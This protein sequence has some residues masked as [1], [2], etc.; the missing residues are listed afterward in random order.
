MVDRCNLQCGAAGCNSA[1]PPDAAACRHYTDVVL[2]CVLA[3]CTLQ[4]DAI[5]GVYLGIS[6]FMFRQAA[7]VPLPASGGP[8]PKPGSSHGLICRR[9]ADL[10]HRRNRL[11]VWLPLYNFLVMLAVLAYQSPWEQLLDRPT[12]S[13]WV[14]AHAQLL[15]ALPDCVGHTALQP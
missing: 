12:I 4:L 2:V 15:Q 6:L 11:F 3:L 7:W 1:G 5:H 9:R 8:V 13:A 10:A 14:W